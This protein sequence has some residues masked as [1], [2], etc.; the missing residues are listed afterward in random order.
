MSMT[1]GLAGKPNAGKSTFFKAATM[2]D[3]EIA[4]YPFTTINANKGVTYV[5]AECPCIEQSKRCG[6]CVEGIRYVPIELIDVAGL[7]PDAH[8]G[9]GL[10]N[11]F[12]DELRQ[13]Q[14]IIHVID[15]SGG[16]DIEGNPV[17]VGEHNPMEDVDFLNREITMWMFGI[18]KRNWD[19]LARKIQ[20]EGL[21]IEKVLS[22]QL[23][24]AGVDEYHVSY[25]LTKCSLD[26]NHVKWSDDDLIRLCD[27]I[28]TISKP[29]IIAANKADIAPENFVSDL[30]SL[31]Q[32]VVPTSAAAELV[33]KSASKG[34]AIK[35]DS[36]DSDFTIIKEELT[37]AQKKGLESVYMLLEK[38]GGTGIQECINKSVFDLLD[39]II[40]Y[41]V[42]D[43]GKWTDKND[44]MLP[45][46]FLMKKGS[47]AHDLAYKVHS[48]IGDRFLYAVDAKTKMRLGEKHELNDGDVVKIVSTAK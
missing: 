40:V 29:T 37:S 6:N 30:Q 1:I 43:E 9:R 32:I 3:V 18:V 20:A 31:D 12:L 14:A 34:G 33:L 47:T 7:V 5:R 19:R 48:D 8:Q 45:D 13:A 2:A 15:A 21:K 24:G 26:H 35:Y 25:S 44:R 46:A 39:L 23:A 38:M 41:P 42:E 28:R 36:G 16:T 22:E 11:T 10:G 17:D 4:N 27:G